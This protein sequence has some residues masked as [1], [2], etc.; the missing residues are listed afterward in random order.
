MYGSTARGIIGGSQYVA[1]AVLFDGADYLSRG[2]S[3]TGL[4]DAKTFTLS[5]WVKFTSFVAN[6]PIIRTG[7]G[8]QG[9]VRV[10]SSGQLSMIFEDSTGAR[11]LN[12]T[13]SSGSNFSTGQWYHVAISVDLTNSSNRAVYYNGSAVTVTWSTYSNTNMDL[14]NGGFYVGYN[15]DSGVIISADIADLWFNNTYLALSSNIN[16]FILQGKPVSLGATGENPSGSQPIL[17]LSRLGGNTPTD[18]ATNKGSGGGMTVT[19]TLT[20]SSTSPST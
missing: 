6:A 5:F 7:A 20:A 1:Q 11:V 19:G 16:K 15:P 9:Y 10:S 2:A 17:Y 13:V 3:L 18:F 4:V 12:A 8:T 14:A